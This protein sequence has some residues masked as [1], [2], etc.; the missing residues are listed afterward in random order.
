MLLALDKQVDIAFLLH[1]EI[2]T[3]HGHCLEEG[4]EL[5]QERSVGVRRV[6]RRVTIVNRHEHLECH[7][8]QFVFL[9]F[10]T[11]VDRFEGIFEKSP[12][13]EVGVLLPDE[14]T[15]VRQIIGEFLDFVRKVA[16]VIVDPVARLRISIREDGELEEASDAF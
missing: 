5:C 11:L 7:E 8:E 1:D 15:L 2:S 10:A 16:L 13:E 4:P 6:G 12:F 3:W 14:T 9:K